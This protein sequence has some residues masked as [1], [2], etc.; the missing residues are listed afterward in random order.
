MASFYLGPIVLIWLFH[1]VIRVGTSIAV[2]TTS[3]NCLD[4]QR[5]HTVCFG[6]TPQ[7]IWYN[8]AVCILYNS[9]FRTH[10]SNEYTGIVFGNNIFVSAFK[11]NDVRAGSLTNSTASGNEANIAT[12]QRMRVSTQSN[13]RSTRS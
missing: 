13:G 11:N 9:Y 4:Q 3:S 6:A 5:F 7:W 12:W 10:G 2:S 8:E 1:N